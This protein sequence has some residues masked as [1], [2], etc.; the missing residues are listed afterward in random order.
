MASTNGVLFRMHRVQ[1]PDKISQVPVEDLSRWS[2]NGREFDSIN[3]HTETSTCAHTWTGSA[4]ELD[5]HIREAIDATLAFEAIPENFPEMVMWR[6]FD[7]GEYVQYQYT[8][9]KRGWKYICFK[10]AL[11]QSLA[12]DYRT[13]TAARVNEDD[14]KKNNNSSSS[15]SSSDPDDDDDQPQQKIPVPS[16]DSDD[17]DAPVKTVQQ[18]QQQP[19]Q[20]QSNP[21]QQ[22]QQQQK[23]AIEAII[24]P[25]SRMSLQAKAVHDAKQRD[26]AAAKTKSGALSNTAGA[27]YN[28]TT[29]EIHTGGKSAAALSEDVASKKS[30]PKH[31]KPATKKSAPKKAHAPKLRRQNQ[32][33]S[34]DS[35][36]SDLSINKAPPKKPAGKKAAAKKSKK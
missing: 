18:Q 7:A 3:L 34:H 24:A 20:Q 5:G 14:A 25:Q 27:T 17:G 10:S 33:S 15:S 21:F 23:A 31:K 1:L 6:V 30:A 36:D 11:W 12:L 9:K 26:L 8:H 16:S 28:S 2:E 29:G 4:Q 35:D 13:R 32:Q 22:E 19:Q